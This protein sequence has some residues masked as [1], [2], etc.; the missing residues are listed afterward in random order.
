MKRLLPALALLLAA[1]S[2]PA[3]S[4][5]STSSAV[6]P[7][8]AAAHTI[9]GLFTLYQDDPVEKSSGGAERYCR[10]T[11][12]YEDIVSGLE[13]VV[14]DQSGDIIAADEL[15]YEP[16][17]T[18][19]ATRCE[20]VFTVEDVPDAPFYSVEVGNRGEVTYSRDDLAE[21]DWTVDVQVGQ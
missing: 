15:R 18:Q 14:R 3:A 7:S 21:A 8:A 1:C 17:G 19:T 10:G 13:V 2:P 4:E 20:F 9:E 5:P 16:K 6:V 12:G 11:G